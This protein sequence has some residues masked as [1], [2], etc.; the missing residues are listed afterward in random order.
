MGK[1]ILLWFLALVIT[2]A[3]VIYQRTTGPTYPIEGEV[4]LDGA[5]VEYALLTSHETTGDAVM[6]ISAP[7]TVTGEMRIRRFKSHDEWQ[8]V[9]LPREGEDLLVTIPKQPSAGKVQYEV[10]L[11]DAAGTEYELAPEPVIIRFKDPVPTPVLFPHIFFMFFAMFLANRTGLEAIFNGPKT[12]GM[13]I[14]TAICLA[15][16]GLFLGPVVQKYAFGAFWT[17]WPFGHDLTD[18]KTLFAFIFWAI[19]IWR[20]KPPRSGKLWVIIAAIVTLGVYLIPHSVL[21]SEIDYTQQE[22]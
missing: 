22:G 13:S 5:N 3:A 21:G 18:N 16:G 12:Y 8:T 20:N 17:G 2:L 10:T 11:T 15:I 4:T 1:S 7:V 14:V 9:A 19:A 6:H